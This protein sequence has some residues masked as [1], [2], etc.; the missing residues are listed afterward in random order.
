MIERYRNLT[1]NLLYQFKLVISNLD[2]LELVIFTQVINNAQDRQKI[3]KIQTQRCAKNLNL[4]MLILID[5]L[6]KYLIIFFILKYKKI[7]NRNQ[8]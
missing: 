2:R 5:S 8:N 1:E 4:K 6:I 7:Y 3:F